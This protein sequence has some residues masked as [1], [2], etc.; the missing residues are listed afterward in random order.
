MG[1][2]LAGDMEI[3]PDYSGTAPIT[4]RLEAAIAGDPPLVAG[5]PEIYRRTPSVSSSPLDR[6]AL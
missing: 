6:E 3:A 1:S 2:L 5:D 4:E